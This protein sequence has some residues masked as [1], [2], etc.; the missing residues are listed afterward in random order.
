MLPFT[1]LLQSTFKLN[2]SICFV[3]FVHWLY[4]WLMAERSCARRRHWSHL[5]ASWTTN[6]VRT[7]KRS[8]LANIHNVAAAAA[9]LPKQQQL[10]TRSL[11]LSHTRDS[12]HLLSNYKNIFLAL[13]TLI[14]ICFS[15][16]FV[17]KCWKEMAKPTLSQQNKKHLQQTNKKEKKKVR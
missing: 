17:K 15:E 12:G 13:L 10:L 1:A 3:V 5:L 7:G 9:A 6:A 2:M 11:S 8:A 14:A 4:S 16:S